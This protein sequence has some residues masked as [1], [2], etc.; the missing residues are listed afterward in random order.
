[1]SENKVIYDWLSVTSKIHSPFD[2]VVLL[3]MS[4]VTWE[5]TKGAH[6][7]RDRLYYNGISVHY[8]GREDMGVWLEMSGQ[9]CRAFETYGNGDFENLFAEVKE[10]PQDMHLTRLDVAFDDHD[11]IL[12]MDVICQD[13]LAGNFVSPST[14]WEV[15]Q[16]SKGQCVM[17]GAPSSSV[18]IRIYDKAR[19]RG[20]TDGKPWTRVE[21][22]L[23][24]DRAR[25]FTA[26]PYSFGEKW[27]GVLLNYLRYVVPNPEDSNKSRWETADYWLDLLWFASA[28]SIYEKP[29]VDY[30]IMHC[31]RYV[32]EM[33][34]NAVD[35]LLNCYGID[36]FL[37]QLKKRK[38]KQN[39]KY[40]RIVEQ[41]QNMKKEKEN[42]GNDQEN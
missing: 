13:T 3:G 41:Y 2:F 24:N 33:A 15:I 26:L 34:G 1:M 21:L 30:N 9:G 8:N 32:F 35:T 38:P 42:Y 23:R 27:C 19:E 36:E 5:E 18:L 37:E 39:P 10:N 16:S 28:L 12:D 4:G 31:E 6:G 11:G 20:L 14:Y 17:I 25:M 40:Q 7:Y 29:G 22:Q